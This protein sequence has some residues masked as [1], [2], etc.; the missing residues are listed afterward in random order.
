MYIHVVVVLRYTIYTAELIW[1][2]IDGGSLEPGKGQRYFLSRSSGR[3]SMCLY[4]T[5]ITAGFYTMNQIQH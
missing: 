3:Y 4:Y 1:L 2:E 5:V